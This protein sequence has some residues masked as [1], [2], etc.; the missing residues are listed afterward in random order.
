MVNMHWSQLYLSILSHDMRRCTLTRCKLLTNSN[1]QHDESV[2]IVINLFLVNVMHVSIFN[3]C[4]KEQRLKGLN[5][6]P[7]VSFYPP[8]SL[9]CFHFMM[10]NAGLRG[11][12][13]FFIYSRVSGLWRFPWLQFPKFTSLIGLCSSWICFIA[14]CVELVF[15]V[16][17]LNR[18]FRISLSII[19]REGVWGYEHA[20]PQGMQ[21]SIKSRLCFILHSQNSHKIGILILSISIFITAVMWLSIVFSLSFYNDFPSWIYSS[22]VLCSA[23]LGFISLQKYQKAHLLLI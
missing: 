11:R 10:S 9:L 2:N 1:S 23:S 22:C 6:T 21:I 17:D 19:V 5:L 14:M 4:I 20:P 18:A 3:S 8:F 13:V 12:L 16:C 7:Y 15:F